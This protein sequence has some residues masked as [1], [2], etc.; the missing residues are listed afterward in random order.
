V[1]A[2]RTLE[3][4]QVTKGRILCLSGHESVTIAD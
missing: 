2:R 3:M 1:V 4:R